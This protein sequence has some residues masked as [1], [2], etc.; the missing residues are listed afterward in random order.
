MHD[1]ESQLILAALQDNRKKTVA[2][3]SYLKEIVRDAK[4]VQCGTPSKAA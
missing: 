2:L 3:L 4:E 1:E